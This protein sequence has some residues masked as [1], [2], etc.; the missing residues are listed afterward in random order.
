MRSPT[1]IRKHVT[2]QIVNALR[3]GGLPPWRKPWSDDSNAPGMHTSLSTGNA[4]RGINQL[5]LQTAAVR[6]GYKSRWW[7]TF[8]QI[9]QNNSVVRKG[10]KAT[11]VLLWKPVCRKRVNENGKEIDEN[12]LVMREF[13]VFN[14]EQAID[15]KQFQVGF[16]RPK[17]QPTERYE[18]ADDVIDST[19]ARIEYG[20]NQPCYRPGADLIEM[21]FRHQF[22]TAEAFY[23]TAF[24]ELVHWAEHKDRVGRS[25]DHKYAFAELVAEI[26]A[27]FL[28]DELGLPNGSTLSNS[29]SYLKGWLKAM[30]DDPKFIFSA[31][32]QASKCVDHVLS[33]SRQQVEETE[34]ACPF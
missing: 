33:Y 14:A 30:S 26:G 23:E 31:S 29:T 7:G 21:P 15:L 25:K 13:A 18:K 24:H 12:F 5:I 32:A 22:C 19:G 11:K 20:G 9:R 10:Q 3:A 34:V 4:Y 28:M 16:S 1:E 2:G 6:H 17:G 8:N 27:C